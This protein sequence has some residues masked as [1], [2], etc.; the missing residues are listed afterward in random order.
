MELYIKGADAA[1]RLALLEEQS[2]EIERELGCRLEWGDQSPTARDRRIA[3]YCRDVDL[4][5]ESDWSRQ[6]EWFAKYLNQ[7]H[8][9]F[10]QRVRDL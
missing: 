4:D 3:Y 2:D 9:V 10:V 1:E 8:R 5:D 7:M 6:H